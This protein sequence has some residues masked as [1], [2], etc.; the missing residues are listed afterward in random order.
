M[1]KILSAILAAAMLVSAFAFTAAVTADDASGTVV[2]S[3]NY[4]DKNDG[5]VDHHGIVKIS[6]VKKH[7]KNR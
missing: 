5:I 1:K 6:A 2:F 4:S 3:F 7:P